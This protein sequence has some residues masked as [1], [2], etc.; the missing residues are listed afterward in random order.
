MTL[1]LDAATGTLLDQWPLGGHDWVP[2]VPPR[3]VR[4]GAPTLPLPTS[5]ISGCRNTLRAAETTP[6]GR[7]AAVCA[8]GT[9][10]L[11]R[12][13]RPDLLRVATDLRGDH[14]ATALAWTPDGRVV[15]GTLRG[16]V[17]AFAG[18]TGAV[19]ASGTTSLGTI[20]TI[21]VAPDG[22]LVAL[23]GT[24]GGVGLWRLATAS[25]IGEVP[26]ARPRS[27]DLSTTRLR[28]H[29]G[30]LHTWRLPSGTPA[31]VQAT[32]GLAD[33]VVAPT[34]DR[35]VLAGGDGAILTVHLGDGAVDRTSFGDRVVKA[36]AFSPDGASLYATGMAAPFV[37]RFDAPS[38]AW[39][40]APDARP[41]RRLT[42]LADGALLG[43]D[44][45]AAIYRWASPA[46]H[47]LRLA[48]DHTFADLDHDGAT[49]VVLDTH[50]G[51]ARLDGDRVVPLVTRPEA[52]AV[53]VRG[54]RFVVATADS[55]EIHGVEVHGADGIR[56]LEATGASLLEV[57]LSTDGRRVAAGGLDTFIRVWDA[58]TG[59]LLGL[60]PGHQER[61]VGLEFLPD[62]DLVS[63]SWDK[64]A[65]FWALGELTRPVDTLIGAVEAAWGGGGSEGRGLPSSGP[66]R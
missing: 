30:A 1:R 22:G 56:T 23:G 55:L 36:V 13:D 18:D 40:P 48:P 28:I 29:D 53:A 37:A 57:A 5:P 51:V 58:D 10:L 59:Q 39:I 47:P 8:D 61:V 33:V 3:R 14:D 34:G 4:G 7:L 6:D 54:A 26:A 41:L 63:V 45:D 19:V 9:L 20:T 64:S 12:V 31:R 44:L 16:R 60:L 27:F 65:R 42:V 49:V 43:P 25:L 21:A 15:V 32:G 46:S 35:V 2:Q 11:G 50:G 24:L 62:G 38:A 52:R 17:V 66:R